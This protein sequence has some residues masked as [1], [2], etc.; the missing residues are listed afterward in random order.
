VVTAD[1][2]RI[3]S[4]GDPASVNG[5]VKQSFKHERHGHKIPR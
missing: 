2:I 3:P 5:T 1:E 4:A